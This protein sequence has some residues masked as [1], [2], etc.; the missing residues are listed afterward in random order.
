MSHD[1]AVALFESYWAASH[2]F[3][4]VNKQAKESHVAFAMWVFSHDSLKDF[5]FDRVTGELS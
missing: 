4:P 5:K 1:D 3:I 2:P